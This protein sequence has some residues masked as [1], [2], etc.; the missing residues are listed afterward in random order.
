MELKLIFQSYP[1]LALAGILIIGVTFA[2][3]A[4]HFLFMI[5]LPVKRFAQ[6]KIESES[7]VYNPQ[8]GFTLADGGERIEEGKEVKDE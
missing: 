2:Y 5:V 3:L 6:A 1:I 8:L 4:W 7:L